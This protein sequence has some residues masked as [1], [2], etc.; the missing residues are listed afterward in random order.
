MA[1]VTGVVVYDLE[2]TTWEGAR[3]RRWSGPGEHRE[4]VQVG[5]V[6]LDDGAELSLL[7]K[8]RLN[9]GLSTYFTDLTGI[10]QDQVDRAGMDFPEALCRLADFAAGADLGS[11]GADEGVLRENCALTG[12]AFPFDGR[13]RDLAPLLITAAGAQAHIYSCEMA[14]T[15]GL[16][17]DQRAH[18]ALGDAR[19]V[20]QV[21]RHLLKTGRVRPSDLL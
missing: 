16:N 14:A 6:R 1:K 2:Y 5:A 19:Q 12:C 17:A 3:E 9:P 8:P 13:C 15:F 11:N 21:L 10:T 4:V 18:D 20:A 7:V